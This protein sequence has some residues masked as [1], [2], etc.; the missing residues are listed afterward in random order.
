MTP[1]ILSIIAD[2]R[3][4]IVEQ[5]ADAISAHQGNWLESSLANLAG[6]FAGIVRLE[7]PEAQRDALCE[8]LDALTSKG[9]K[10]SIDATDARVSAHKA[11]VHI[12]VTGSDRPGIVR[13]ITALLARQHVNVHELHTQCESAPMSG[14]H[15]FVASLKVVLPDGMDEHDLS[16]TLESISSDLVV[17]TEVL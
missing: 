4:G 8:A 7:V 1:L 6:K 5:V 13:E 9:V 16:D 17:D 3:P 11:R 12:T 10:I 2:D 14:D 15:L